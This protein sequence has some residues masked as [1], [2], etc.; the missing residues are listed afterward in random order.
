M[1]SILLLLLPACNRPVDKEA[2]KQAIL[3]LL[4]QERKAHFN[5]DV[6]LFVSEFAQGMYSVNK[7]TVDSS[8]IDE[9]KKHIH[10][11]FDA[12]KFI[13]W[14]DVAEPIIRF[15]NDHSIAYAIIQKQ[16]I[17]ETQDSTGKTIRDATD[18]AWT[19]I[20]RKQNNEWKIECNTSTNK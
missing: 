7:G 4:Q 16:V 11:Y 2:D 17:L 20:Y 13:K 12:V 1:I 8:S 19:S 6:N 5:K 10:A 15:S 3:T 18:F 9:H 14:D